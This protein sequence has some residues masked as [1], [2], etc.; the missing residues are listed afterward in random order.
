M[1][2]TTDDNKKWE[3][4]DDVHTLIRAQEVLNDS[5]RCKRAITELKK[6]NAATDDAQAL[7]ESKVSKKLKKAFGRGK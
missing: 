7:L 1:A 3:T 6:Q 4:E 5:A 2:I